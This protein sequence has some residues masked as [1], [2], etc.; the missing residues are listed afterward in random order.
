M[1]EGTQIELR[2][3]QHGSASYAASCR[4]RHEVLRKPL[5]LDLFVEN[6]ELEKS[7][8]HF[9][10][11]EGNAIVACLVVVPLGDGCAKLRQMAVALD[12][13]RHGFG[14]RLIQAVEARLV[15]MGFWHVELHARRTAEGFYNQVGYRRRGEEF[16]EVGIPHIAMEKR[17]DRAS[18]NLGK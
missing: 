2:E 16:V 17:F 7:H 1:Q 11:F 10:L 8:H 15:N 12:H 14:R 9:G 6:L 5:G 18:G 3:I 13:Q 4:L